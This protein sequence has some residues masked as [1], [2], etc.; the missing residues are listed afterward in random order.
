MAFRRR[1]APEKEPP[2][3]SL[4]AARSKAFVLL[5][6]RDLTPKELEERLRRYGFAEETASEVCRDLEASG[7]LDPR[8]VAELLARSE[9]CKGHGRSIVSRKLRERG[10]PGE[11]AEEVLGNANPEDEAVRIEEL[12][13]KRARSLPSGLTAQARSKKLF[14]HLVRR[15]YAPGTV[16][17]I[18]REKGESFDDDNPEVDL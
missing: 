10:V 12:L 11:V 5:G 3:L 9:D 15:G 4:A 13:R 7:Y 17:R 18:L 2:G 1:A 8:R 14:D 6:R 16:L